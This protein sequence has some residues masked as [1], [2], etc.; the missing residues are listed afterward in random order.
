VRDQR[1]K[2]YDDGTLFDVERDPREKSPVKEL[3]TE[4]ARAREKLT[5]VTRSLDY[6]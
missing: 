2:L 3:S 4:A 6:K 5:A 1:W